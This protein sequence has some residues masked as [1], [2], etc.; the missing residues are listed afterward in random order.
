MAK[1]DGPVIEMTAD[2][3]FIE[4]PKPKLGTILVR[5]AL[6]GVALC[7]A[8]LM[9]WT[10]LFVI[11]VLIVLGLLGFLAAKVQIRRF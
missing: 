11:P 6:F 4:P 1:S 2:G 9:F 5:L 10:A 8:A 7:V 3:S